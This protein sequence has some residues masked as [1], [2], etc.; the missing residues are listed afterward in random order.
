MKTRI[1]MKPLLT[2]VAVFCASRILADTVKATREPG[3]FASP[4]NACTAV[5]RRSSQ[6]GFLQLYL[7]HDKNH[8]AR[9]AD[10]VT[11]FAW[12]SPNSVVYSV[13][14]V[15]GHPGVFLA[16]CSSRSAITIL[17]APKNIDKAY[18]HGAD[19]FELLSINGNHVEYFYGEDV[20]TIDFE[21]L[22]TDNNLRGF[23]LP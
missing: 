3:H 20:D 16:R 9:V 17:V 8:V 22:R 13:S 18:P 7:G 14:P 1:L 15:Y 10:D 23:D 6:G 19:Y 4:G 11:A 21:R 5:L 2:I 12:A